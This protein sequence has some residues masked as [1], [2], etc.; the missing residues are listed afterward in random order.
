MEHYL[1]GQP[2]NEYSQA[3]V[4]RKKAWPIAAE[5]ARYLSH[6]VL[7]K[8]STSHFRNRNFVHAAASKV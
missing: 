3:A 6:R 4:A 7:E 1:R 8:T 2:P 5:R